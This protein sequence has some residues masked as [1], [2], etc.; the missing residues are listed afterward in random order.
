MDRHGLRPRD[1]EWVLRPRHDDIESMY[2]MSASLMLIRYFLIVATLFIA[3]NA[4]AITADEVKAVASGESDARVAALNKAM[5]TADDKTAAFLQAL[6][7]DAVKVAGTRYS[8]SKT[9]RGSIR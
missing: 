2:A 3:V 8:L 7:D 9:A 6:S 5:T 4:H 1:D